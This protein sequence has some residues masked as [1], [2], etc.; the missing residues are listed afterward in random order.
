MRP[1]FKFTYNGVEVRD[2]TVAKP[3]P[4]DAFLVRTLRFK[5]ASPPASLFF[6]AAVGNEIA[7]QPDGSWLIDGR[8]KMKFPSAP[9]WANTRT[10]AGKTELL[11]PVSFDANGAGEIVQEI[12]W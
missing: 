9:G 1:A 10:I 12:I 3:G 11:V 5:S 8:V 6:R 4:V 2:Y 7:K